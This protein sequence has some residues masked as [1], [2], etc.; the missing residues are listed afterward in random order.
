MQTDAFLTHDDGAYVEFGR[1]FDERVDR[2]GK[3]E[4]HPFCL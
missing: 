2:I 4:F 1:G 3:K